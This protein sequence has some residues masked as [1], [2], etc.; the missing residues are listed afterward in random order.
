VLRRGVRVAV[1]GPV[2]AVVAEVW[3]LVVGAGALALAAVAA[4]LGAA[5]LAVRVP[6]ARG[7]AAVLLVG[8]LA[9]ALLGAAWRSR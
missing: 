9:V 3:G 7:W 2:A 4:V 6:D 1:P 5:V 8:G